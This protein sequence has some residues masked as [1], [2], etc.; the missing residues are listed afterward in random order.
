MSHRACVMVA[1]AEDVIRSQVRL[2]LGDERFDV[3][4]AEDTDAVVLHVASAVPE[5]L[6]VD[7][8]LP[9]AGALALAG[10]LRTQRSTS[11]LRTLLLVERGDE[12]ADH[13]L[14]IDATLT[15]PVTGFALLRK[16]EALLVTT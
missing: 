16:V 9:G 8:C 5:L 13:Q 4:E 7:R 11:H 14:G 10:T 3:H 2:I 12:P 1:S 15:V 6:V